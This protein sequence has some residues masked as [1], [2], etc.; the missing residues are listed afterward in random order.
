MA[1]PDKKPVVHPLLIKLLRSRDEHVLTALSAIF[2]RNGFAV[3]AETRELLDEL[4][5]HPRILKN[6][7]AEHLPEMLAKLVTAEPDRVCRVAHALIDTAGEQMGNIATSWFLSTEWLLDI[8]LQLQDLGINERE[9]GS[10]LFERM[11]EFNMPQAREMTLN[12][13]KRTPVGNS[14]QAPV[15]RRSRVKRRKPEGGY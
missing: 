15:R 1:R 4:V 12:L 8:A 13:D 7:R 10:A 11:L 14:S 6:G 2:L 3:D 5:A 9:A